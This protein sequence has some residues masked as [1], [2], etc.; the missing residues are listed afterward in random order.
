[1]GSEWVGWGW[2]TRR[3]NVRRIGRTH[4]MW[5]A[6]LTWESVS[7]VSLVGHGHLR[8]IRDYDGTLHTRT[9]QQWS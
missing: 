6:T 5:M 3:K 8:C 1:M 7:R 2:R 9:C 4:I